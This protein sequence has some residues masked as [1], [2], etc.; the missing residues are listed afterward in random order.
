MASIHKQF[1]MVL[2]YS[3]RVHK[4]QFV[5]S[6]TQFWRRQDEQLNSSTITEKAYQ[7]N[8]EVSTTLSLSNVLMRHQIVCQLYSIAPST[9][10]SHL[11]YA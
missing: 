6:A 2:F 11:T 4:V 10:L 1:P 5:W 3:K 8:W 9:M 7:L